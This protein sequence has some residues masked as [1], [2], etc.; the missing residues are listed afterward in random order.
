MPDEMRT[1]LTE[2]Q[3]T[4]QTKFGP[5][6]FIVETAQ[7]SPKHLTVALGTPNLACLD[8]NLNAQCKDK[9]TLAP[10][11]IKV[12]LPLLSGRYKHVEIVPKT[13]KLLLRSRKPIYFERSLGQAPS[14]HILI[15]AEGMAKVHNQAAVKT[16]LSKIADPEGKAFWSQKS[17]DGQP[18]DV[19]KVVKRFQVAAR[20]QPS[21]KIDAD[22]EKALLSALP[23]GHEAHPRGAGNRICHPRRLTDK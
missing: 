7:A 15:D 13:D 2:I 8:Q 4:A 22:T 5:S 10:E 20:L 14:G 16:A 23:R 3:K 19:T 6:L 1:D 21:G 9:D 18:A 17:S 12:L 11:V